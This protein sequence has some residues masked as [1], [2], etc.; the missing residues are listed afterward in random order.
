MTDHLRSQGVA[1]K[2]KRVG[3]TF[4]SL[5]KLVLKGNVFIYPLSYI[6]LIDVYAYNNVY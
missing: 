6:A 4:S 1:K 5:T 3:L 2:L